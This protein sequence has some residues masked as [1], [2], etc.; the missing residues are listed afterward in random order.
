M[1]AIKA[2]KSPSLSTSTAII[3]PLFSSPQDTA[4]AA[5][6]NKQKGRQKNPLLSPFFSSPLPP[7]LPCTYYY[8]ATMGGKRPRRRGQRE[9]GGEEGA[10]QNSSFYPGGVIATLNSL[11][12]FRE[13]GG[14]AKK[15][16]GFVHRWRV[17]RRQRRNRRDCAPPPSVKG[18]LLRSLRFVPI[19]P[20]SPPFFA[21]DSDEGR[22]PATLLFSSPLRRERWG[23]EREEVFAHTSTSLSFPPPPLRNIRARRVACSSRSTYL[24]I[25]LPTHAFPPS[26]LHSR[27]IRVAAAAR[28]QQVCGEGEKLVVLQGVATGPGG[29]CGGDCADGEGGRQ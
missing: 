13:A 7:F 27:F 3:T 25:Y 2:L 11:I 5:T 4:A 28:Q 19:L 16:F 14:G 24:P 21:L 17:R 20:P 6:S 18:L 9:R 10:K 12:D 1:P 29:G 23:E 22:T 26:L 15:H 8:Y